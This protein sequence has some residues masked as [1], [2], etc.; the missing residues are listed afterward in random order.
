[1]FSNTLLRTFLWAAMIGS[2]STCLPQ[3]SLPPSPTT[4]SPSCTRQGMS[5]VYAVLPC[6]WWRWF[7]NIQ[8]V[9]KKKN[10]IISTGK[11]KC[12]LTL[13][14]M[15]TKNQNWV[16]FGGCAC[17]FGWLC[18]LLVNHFYF[19]IYFLQEGKNTLLIQL[20]I[21]FRIVS[22]EQP[23]SLGIWDKC[24]NGWEESGGHLYAVRY[25]RHPHCHL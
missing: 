23:P 14:L 12:L 21:S 1:M 9:R 6:P 10:P 18:Q 8:I 19:K 13:S 7:S 17:V 5:P 25:Q 20:E 4:T 2:C 24:V 16:S 22:K 11:L 15:D 3:P